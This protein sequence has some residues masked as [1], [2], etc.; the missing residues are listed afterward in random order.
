MRVLYLIVSAT[1]LVFIVGIFPVFLLICVNEF[2]RPFTETRVIGA[3]FCGAVAFILWQEM[4]VG[5]PVNRYIERRQVPST[6]EVVDVRLVNNGR[7][8]YTLSYI[9]L[10][11]A[12]RTRKVRYPTLL[13]VGQTVPIFLEPNRPDFVKV[14]RPK[15]TAIGW[16]LWLLAPIGF[17]TATV[18]LLAS[19][20]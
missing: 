12:Q 20:P 13:R 18:L 6:A 7:N 17:T 19:G 8:R 5:A 9:D 15:P 14:V 3:V 10:A 4:L 2:V 11:G 1:R 16:T